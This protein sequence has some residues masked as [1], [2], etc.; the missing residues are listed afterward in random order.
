MPGCFF[1]VEVC[2][3]IC[4]LPKPRDAFCNRAEHAH[5]FI[6]FSGPELL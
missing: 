3:D 5:D 1:A 4:I 6:Q 2:F